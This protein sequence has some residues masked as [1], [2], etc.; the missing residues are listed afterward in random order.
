MAGKEVF[1]RADSK[2]GTWW[3]RFTKPDGT[4]VR[5]SAG[6]TNRRQAEELLAQLKADAWETQRLGLPMSHHWEEAVIRYMNEAINAGRSEKSLRNDRDALIWLG[7]HMEGRTMDEITPR[8]IA[9]LTEKRREPYTIT[10]GS[11]K[12]RVCAPG[13]DT[14]NRFLTV[15]RALLNKAESW[16]WLLRAPKVPKVKGE[17]QRS[18]WLTRE[19]ADRLIGFLPRHLALMAEFSL[20]TGL[21]RANV[22][23]LRWQNVDLVRR[24]VFVS[25]E[26]TKTGTGICIPLSNKALEVLLSAQGMHE[27]YCFAFRGHPITQTSTKAWR[28][29]L[30]KAGITNFNWHGLRHTWASWMAQKDIPDRA[31]MKLGGWKSARMLTRYS[32]MRI[33]HLRQFV[34]DEPHK[35]VVGVAK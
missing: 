21:R 7:K 4:R 14:V 34:E 12:T 3:I 19:E 1:R 27:S 32:H 15:F 33:E 2:T 23:G 28:A 17:K 18:R 24:V 6:T 10:F 30:E 31:L 35:S 16:G 20:Q 26:E 8:M 9:D 25:P 29:A 5:Q 22:T 11:G 13:P